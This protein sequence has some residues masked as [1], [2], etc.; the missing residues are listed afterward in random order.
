MAA[1][2][3]GCRYQA[4]HVP[5]PATAPGPSCSLSRA[6]HAGPGA[7]EVCRSLATD[8]TLHSPAFSCFFLLFPIYL[9]LRS[10]SEAL[11]AACLG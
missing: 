4:G 9:A 10:S 6:Q 8:F 2:R 1:D 3:S 11:L 7:N 5:T